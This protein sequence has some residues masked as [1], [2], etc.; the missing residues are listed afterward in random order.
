MPRLRVAA[1]GPSSSAAA[2][3][4]STSAQQQQQQR[5]P[6][7]RGR[8]HRGCRGR[9]RRKQQP[10]ESDHTRRSPSPSSPS[11][12]R[13]RD[14]PDLCFIDR[15]KDTGQWEAKYEYL[16]I[17]VQISDTRP[18]VTP[19]Q[20]RVA[21]AN[22]CGIL[23]DDRLKI[24]PAA[25]P[26][27][28]L[29]IAPD[30]G[31]YLSVLAGNRMIQTPA[32]TLL[33]R[34]WHQ[35]IYAD[36]AALYHKVQIDIEGIPPHVWEHSTVA[37]LLQGYCSIEFVHPDTLN[38]RDLSTFSL[39]AWTTRPKRIPES[40]TLCVP[41]PFE[42]ELLLQPMRHTLRY[43]VQIRVRRLIVQLP[44]DSPPPSPPP[45]ATSTQ[46]PAT[47]SH[48]SGIQNDLA[49]HEDPGVVGSSA[50]RRHRRPHSKC[51][52][53]PETMV[54]SPWKPSYP[55]RQTHQPRTMH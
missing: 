26:Y 41:E 20:A 52:G 25:L 4:G 48:R 54:R 38:W 30:H 39:T 34:P 14:D 10:S 17:L 22:Q 31:A 47:T 35:L 18:P 8:R 28:F 32:F 23:L 1:G 55:L 44:S 43:P 2:A 5:Q 16:G 21:I 12:E 53:A 37:A 6:R 42:A 49:G 36:F 51:V 15:T 19:E 50:R 7:Q 45:T 13:W 27:D 11:P 46:S 9:G 33:V 24:H 40:R 29:L 3:G